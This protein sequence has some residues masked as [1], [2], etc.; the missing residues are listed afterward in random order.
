MS[1]IQ[2]ELKH[3]LLCILKFSKK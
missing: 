1:K 3:P 2:Q